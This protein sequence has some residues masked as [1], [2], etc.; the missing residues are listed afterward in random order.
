MDY[1]VLTISREFGSGGGRIAK[2][3]AE[4]LGWKLLDRE[5]IEAIAHS[6]HVDA[7]VVSRFDERAES[8]MGRMNRQA[9][10]GAALAAGVVPDNEN[11]FD[12]DVMTEVTRR[13]VARAYEE[14]NCV[15]VGRG[16]QFILQH[17]PD[18]FHVFIYAPFCDRMTRLRSRLGQG[19]NIEER[20][21]IVDGERAH[22]LRQRFGKE[23]NNPHLYDLMISSHADEESTAHVILNAMTSR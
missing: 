4:W 8:W 18:V 3:V 11:C 1:R 13:I 2:M 16:A 15:I 7:H 23:W 17:K 6:A 5:L 19:V 12:P 9:M 14:G 20:I 22:Y 10:R 21:H